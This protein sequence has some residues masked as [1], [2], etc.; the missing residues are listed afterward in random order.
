MKIFNFRGDCTKDTEHLQHLANIIEEYAQESKLTVLISAADQTRSALEKVTENFY[1][2][3][4]EEALKLFET[5]KKQHLDTAKYLLILNFNEC[6]ER[7]VDIFTEVEWL[8]HDKPVWSYRYYY[9]Q[10]VCVGELLI[11]R[12][13]SAYLEE[14]KTANTFVDIRDVLRT[15]S[16]FTS[17]EID[18]TETQARASEQLKK[19]FDNNNVLVTQGFI[20][21]TDENEST[22]LGKLGSDYTAAVLAKILNAEEVII[23]QLEKGI[24]A[25]TYFPFA[26]ATFLHHLNFN[27]AINIT[28]NS[29]NILHEKAIPVLADANIPLDYR[30]FY[31][32][33]VERTKISSENPIEAKQPIIVVKENQALINCTLTEDG[34]RDDISEDINSLADELL[35][36]INMMQ[37][38]KNQLQ[39]VVNDIP[40]K[41]ESFAQK[42]GAVYDVHIEK[43]VKIVS[44]INAD[45]SEAD[46]YISPGN[47]II[48]K[49]EENITRILTK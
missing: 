15:N 25:N 12:I 23:W 28:T 21:C 27:E 1:Q 22:T 5:V 41:I 37:V 43:G 8:L 9:D 11:T 45:A 35:L 44:F 16:D 6:L 14:K 38:E 30:Y 10:I 32:T 7:M 4:K 20:G 49:T 48:T 33:S 26:D 42:V 24:K 19:V 13:M 39:L 47:R 17:A 36:K 46:K 3:N 40:D 18:M 34:L 29:E 31:D 2:G